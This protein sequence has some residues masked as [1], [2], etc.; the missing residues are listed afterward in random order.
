MKSGE[1]DEG[2]GGAGRGSVVGTAVACENGG[3]TQIWTVTVTFSRIYFLPPPLVSYTTPRRRH[4]VSRRRA[5]AE[6]RCRCNRISRRKA[7]WTA[8]ARPFLRFKV[9][10]EDG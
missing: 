9:G 5:A 8:L 1:V 6:F 2:D 4:L 3:S 7:N 10:F